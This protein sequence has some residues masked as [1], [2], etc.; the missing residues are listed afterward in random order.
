MTTMQRFAS[1][2]L[3]A[4][5]SALVFCGSFSDM[6]LPPE[7]VESS[8]DL[9]DYAVLVWV[10]LLGFFAALPDGLGKLLQPLDF[11]LVL[12]IFGGGL[13]GM[14]FGVLSLLLKPLARFI[15]LYL[16]KNNWKDEETKKVA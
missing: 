14:L 1:F 4:G 6:A 16:L 13:V 7:G 10:V 3:I 8:Y 15:G 9:K 5:H 12:C 11:T 2:T